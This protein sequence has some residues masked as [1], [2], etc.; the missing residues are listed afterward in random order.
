MVCNL[1]AFYASSRLK[2]HLLQKTTLENYIMPLTSHA[3]SSSSLCVQDSTISPDIT[4][5][6][7][8]AMILAAGFGSRMKNLTEDCPKPMLPYHGRPIIDYTIER[9][10][11]CGVQKIII[12][13]H[14]QADI[15]K[16][17]LQG[18][19]DICLIF[20]EDILETGGG[21]KNA[22]PFIP[23]HEPL[24]VINGDSF[25]DDAPH[26]DL[27]PSTQATLSTEKGSEHSTPKEKQAYP[28]GFQTLLMLR[29]KWDMISNPRESML[30]LLYPATKERE[31]WER[32]DLG[33]ED[34]GREDL[35][36]KN[37]EKENLRQ[38][39]LEKRSLEKRDLEKRSLGQENL[40]SGDF[41]YKTHE[42]PTLTQ[43]NQKAM[44]TKTHL[45]Q[46]VSSV[47]GITWSS[48]QPKR[49]DPHESSFNEPSISEK[50]YFFTGIQVVHPALYPIVPE[51]QFSNKKLFIQCEKNN[52][53]YGTTLRG[54][55]Y[56]FNTPE[57]LERPYL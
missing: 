7:K 22:L 9:L 47:H 34:L 26:E 40:K 14:H 54:L 29:R 17:H 13:M 38:E 55:W 8:T 57:S 24:L 50:S 52:T 48:H 44:D 18:Q 2:K 23:P 15:I 30:L 28:R 37:L 11:A 12:N 39:A 16:Q 46:E 56:H 35:E 53:L 42:H 4:P 41:V 3:L 33:R 6:F 43:Q 49:Q 5:P 31:D 36:H 10:R 51:R 21:I 25:W 1:Y 20:E 45:S 32:E 19:E 27:P